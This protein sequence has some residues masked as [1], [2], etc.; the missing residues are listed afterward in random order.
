MKPVL[1]RIGAVILQIGLPFLPLII[2]HDFIVFKDAQTVLSGFSV[3]ILIV[4]SPIL[5]KTLQGRTMTPTVTKLWVAVLAVCLLLEPLIY[6][7]KIIAALGA[8]GNL[9][10]KFM[11]ARANKIKQAKDAEKQ[12]KSIAES[13]KESL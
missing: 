3:L 12:A 2:K 11:Y 8:A 6:Q 5:A 1:L 4:S 7:L 9:A 10:A 13:V